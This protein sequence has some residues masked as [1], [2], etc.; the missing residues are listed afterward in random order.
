M[1][2]FLVLGLVSFALAAPAMADVANN[3][4]AEDKL[5]CKKHVEI[6]SLVKKRK[7]C[8]TREQWDRIATSQA[9]GARR[10]VDDL[11]GRPFGGD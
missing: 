5:I 3:G 9:D 8:F 4:I 6:G 10:L 2:R 11:R 7:Q 1:K